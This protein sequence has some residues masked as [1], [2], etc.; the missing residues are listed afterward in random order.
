MIAEIKRSTDFENFSFGVNRPIDEK[1]VAKLEATIAASGYFHE[2]PIVV[3]QKEDKLVIIDGQH[4]F[5]ACKKLGIEFSY[6]VVEIG[7]EDKWVK[8]LK[9]ANRVQKKWTIMDHIRLK[10]ITD[11]KLADIVK[12]VELNSN[13]P[14]DFI[15]SYAH[16]NNTSNITRMAYR[17]IDIEELKVAV[18]YYCTLTSFGKVSSRA[19][20]TAVRI[21]IQQKLDIGRLINNINKQPAKYVNC[22]TTEQYMAMVEYF[23]NYD[24]AAKNRVEF[25]N[26]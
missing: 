1:H 15:L 24:K 25:K 11:P 16:C 13:I 5:A 7:D 3:Q 8:R 12:V 19:M 21:M 14:S 9:I 10:A 4:R 18:S 22:A 23:Y 6:M 17:D 20:I 26:K 2:Y